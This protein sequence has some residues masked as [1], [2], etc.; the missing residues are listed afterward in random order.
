[1]AYGYISDASLSMLAADS[2]SPARASA[3]FTSVYAC[4]RCRPDDTR[5][6]RAMFTAISRRFVA[7]RYAQ[8]G[9]ILCRRV[10]RERCVSASRHSATFIAYIA[11][12]WAAR[13]FYGRDAIVDDDALERE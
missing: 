7:D 3:I 4:C 13:C 2:Q 9:V 5:Y 1:M 10:D 12:C 6:H 11:A 8:R